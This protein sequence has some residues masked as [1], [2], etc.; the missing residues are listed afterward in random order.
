MS[1]L[2]AIKKTIKYCIEILAANIGRHTRSNKSPQLLIIMY[3]RILPSSDIRA[4]QEEPGMLVTPETFKSHL[5]TLSE[6]FEFVSLADWIERKNNGLDL[7]DKACAITFDDGWKD[8]YEFA[9]PILKEQKVPA[10]IYL[11]SD[12]MN[13]DKVFWP[14]RLTYT[15]AL[16]ANEHAH[17]W[18]HPCLA[19]LKEKKCGYQFNQ[20]PPT[21]DQASEIIQNAK[22]LTDDEIQRRLDS[23]YKELEL[24]E[25]HESDAALLNWKQAK[26]MMD[27]GIFE[28]GSHT[29]NHIRLNKHIDKETLKKEIINSKQTLESKLGVDVKT[30]CYPN[31]DYTD[32]AIDVVKN[33]YI[34]A[35]TTESGWNNSESPDYTLQRIAVHDDISKTK[36]SFLSRISGWT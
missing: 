35:V 5:I 3:H 20:I 4:K 21:K 26:E 16:I 8:N 17:L 1:I 34:A 6:Y 9:F 19:W 29:C 22:D 31:G 25:N 32:Q 36:N 14:E 10:T 7:P 27:S 33:E 2:R 12:M 11:V 15:L 13:T 23:I 18:S 28:I 24:T 30:F